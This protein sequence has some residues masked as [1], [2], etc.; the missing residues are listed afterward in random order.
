MPVGLCGVKGQLKFTDLRMES[1]HLRWGVKGW[2]VRGS[3]SRISKRNPS[4]H[5]RSAQSEVGKFGFS[6]PK[7]SCL[8]IRAD[9][10]LL[11]WSGIWLWQDDFFGRTEGRHSWRNWEKIVANIYLGVGTVVSSTGASLWQNFISLS[12]MFSL[13][14]LRVIWERCSFIL[15]LYSPYILILKCFKKLN[16]GGCISFLGQP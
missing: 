2:N 4:Y 8:H 10:G 9:G 1:G 6:L 14:W 13:R 5:Q 3:R 12:T 7:P 11:F 15:K 16:Y